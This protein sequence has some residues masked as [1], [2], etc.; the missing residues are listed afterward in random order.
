MKLDIVCIPIITTIFG[1]AFPI[2]LQVVTSLE[3]KY[4]S[5]YIVD[6]FRKEKV[7]QF[8]LYS[9]IISI[10]SLFLWLFNFPPP[11]I[12]KLTILLV[13]SASKLLILS[14][15]LLI[16]IF[17][18]LVKKIFIYYSPDTLTEKLI[19][20]YNKENNV[21]NFNTIAELLYYSVKKQD[22]TISNTISRFL[23]DVFKKERSSYLNEPIEYPIYFYEL[24]YKLTQELSLLNINKLK[25]LEYQAIG[26]IWLLGEFEESNVSETTFT[27]LWRNLLLATSYEK[28]DMIVHYWKRAHQYISHNLETIV[29][30][31]VKREIANKDVIS[32]REEE[33]ERFLEFHYALGGLLL[34]K[35]RFSCLARLFKYTSNIPPR[36]E[37]FSE[38]ISEIFSQYINFIDPYEKK[39]S[40]IAYK[41]NFPD[42]E[43][44]LSD[45]IIKK[46]ICSYV[47]LLLIRVYSTPRQI[48]NEENLKLTEIPSIQGIKKVWIDNLDYF[49]KLITEILESNELVNAIGLKFL[50]KD[51]CEKNKM[52]YPPEVIEV[53]KNRILES[54]NVEESE[55]KISPDKKTKFISS[56]NEIIKE[57]IDEYKEIFNTN[58]K[59]TNIQSWY[60]YGERAIVDKSAFVDNQGVDHLNYHLFLAETVSKKFKKAIAGLFY[61]CRSQTYMIKETEV[62]QAIENLKINSKDHIIISFGINILY[63][64]DT[65]KI[66][67][68]TEKTYRDVK[69]FSFE[70]TDHN[71]VGDSLF[72]LE[73]NDLPS[74]L[75]LPIKEEDTHKYH[76]ELINNDIK[77]YASLIDLNEDIEL[78]NEFK[79]YEQNRDITKRVL[80]NVSFLIETKWKK[81]A[82][83]IQI[84]LYSEYRDQGLPNKI[85]DV[86]PIT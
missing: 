43:G 18:F 21:K 61:N 81:N 32:K 45:Y 71:I 63:F 16:V 10:I 30:I 79:E 38:N 23:N 9:L 36:F 19:C 48:I 51:W 64:M 65:Y 68:L 78:Q 33:R 37:L 44:L 66:N 12:G 28:D 35:K 55:Q 8:F 57:T 27:W 47:A 3:E 84:K 14:T 82:N 42:Q 50:N 22:E 72:V 76:L 60:I 11:N 74:I 41:Y 39:Y 13:D 49:K 85:N 53:I 2:L 73:K 77:L 86:K 4:S 46:W 62:F 31:Y 54:Y 1:I 69:L 20:R 59:D 6:F 29:P 52:I 7:S 83:I 67:D 15:I 40:W 25:F 58:L 56:T 75:H 80:V 17:F 34:Y 70:Y 24:T 26:G 5:K